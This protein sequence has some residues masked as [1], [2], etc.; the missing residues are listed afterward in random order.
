MTILVPYKDLKCKNCP[1]PESALFKVICCNDTA[2]LRK[3]MNR[4]DESYNQVSETLEK[5][6]YMLKDL[7][8]GPDDGDI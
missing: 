4:D 3:R 1:H 7:E 5:T 2:E 8:N 6:E